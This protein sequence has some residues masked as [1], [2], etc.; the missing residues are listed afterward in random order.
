[1]ATCFST[2]PAAGRGRG[3]SVTGKS[4]SRLASE[5]GKYFPKWLTSWNFCLGKIADR[6]L[7]QQLGALDCVGQQVKVLGYGVV[8]SNSIGNVP[9]DLRPGW[10]GDDSGSAQEGC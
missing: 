5:L 8:S 6:R 4:V 10:R 1:M 9:F 3:D 7:G 2:R